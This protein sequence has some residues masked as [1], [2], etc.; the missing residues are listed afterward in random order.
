ME[1]ADRVRQHFGVP[2]V[3]SSGLRCKTHN[4]NVGGVA[5]SRH[6]SGRAMDFCVTGRT[7]AEV[8]SYVRQQPEV[9]YAYAIDGQYVHMDV[10]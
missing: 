5:N 2:V 3:V 8:L 4:A 10:A 6:L 1:L 9:R 7:S